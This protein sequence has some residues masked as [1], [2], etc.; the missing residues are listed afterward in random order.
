MP[1]TEQQLPSKIDLLIRNAV[2]ITMDLKNSVIEN[3]FIAITGNQITN[4]GQDKSIDLSKYDVKRSIDLHGSIVHPGYI[5]SHIHLLYQPL[6]WVQKD[7]IHASDAMSVHSEYLNNITPEIEELSYQLASL[8]MAHNG[9]TCFLEANVIDTNIAA[10]AIEKIGIRAVIGT[11]GIKD[12]YEE[13]SYFGPIKFSTNRAF[14]L[15]DRELTR[16]QNK[17][18]LVQGAI[19]LHGMGTA[20]DELLLQA[21]SIADKNNVIINMH[22]SYAE[23][24][25]ASDYNRFNQHPMIHYEEIGFLGS[26][27]TFAHVNFVR[28]EEISPILKSGC[29][30][31]WCPLGSMMY[32]IGGTTEGKHSELY[33]KGAQISLGSDSANWTTS[34]DIGN[35]ALIAI[36]T[37]R[38]KTKRPDALLA[39]DGL[40]MATKNGARALGLE[41]KIGSLEIGK[42][43]DLIIRKNNLPEMFPQTDPIRSVIYSGK[44]SIQSVLVDG[45]FI[46]DNGKSTLI[47]ENELYYKVN[48]LKKKYPFYEALFIE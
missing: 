11:P 19:S 40:I 1:L 4:I 20:S 29:S 6:R 3:G 41:N 10:S 26:N 48:N 13:N 42:K 2:I 36:L 46:V 39:E 44:S 45:N 24:D 30:I 21:K 47:D 31:A 33:K 32:G 14:D 27:C 5:D 28:E 35:Q 12:I 18:A 7:G 8:E 9:T 25:T 37:A 38:E 15:I 43:A 16:N 23:D 17:N 34:F 22:Q